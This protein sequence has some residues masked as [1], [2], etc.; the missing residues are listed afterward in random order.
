[1]LNTL[2]VMLFFLEKV[3]YFFNFKVHSEIQ[4][5]C[6]P[7]NLVHNY[8]LIYYTLLKNNITIYSFLTNKN[9][10]CT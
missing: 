8:V 3:Q 5:L 1:M 9:K 4:P 7:N 10:Y 6:R 2:M